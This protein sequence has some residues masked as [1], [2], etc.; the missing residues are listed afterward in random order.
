[1]ANTGWSELEVDEAK[2]IRFLAFV[3]IPEVARGLIIE[4][5]AAMGIEATDGLIGSIM[6]VSAQIT[7]EKAHVNIDDE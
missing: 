6:A 4:D 2:Y 3:M 7:Y 1:M 5:L